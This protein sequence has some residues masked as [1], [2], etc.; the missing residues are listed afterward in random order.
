MLMFPTIMATMEMMENDE[1]A[2]IESIITLLPPLNN[3]LVCRIGERKKSNH[4]YISYSKKILWKKSKKFRNSNKPS[5]KIR[6]VGK[7]ESVVSF[8]SLFISL[9]SLAHHL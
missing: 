5:K 2:V 1:F 6:L 8:R 4:I 3:G 9:I 7:Y